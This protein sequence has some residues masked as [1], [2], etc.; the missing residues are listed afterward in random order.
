MKATRLDLRLDA[1]T[2]G[3]QVRAEAELAFRPQVTGRRFACLIGDVKI[4]GASWNGDPIEA[5]CNP[6]FLALRFPRKVDGFVETTIKLRYTYRPDA[7]GSIQQPTTKEACP[8]RVW[9]TVRRPLLGIL[10]GHL[11]E[12]TEKPPLRT[13][14]WEPPRSRKLALVVADVR[15]FRKTTPSGMNVWLHVHQDLAARAPRLLDLLVDLHEEVAESQRRKLPYADY[16]F[17]EADQRD[18]QPYN[19]LGI[20]VVPRGAFRVEDRPTLY[21]LLAPEVNKEWRRD[22]ATLVTNPNARNPRREGT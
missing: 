7:F 12:G 19:A 10:P 21:G 11:V 4:H 17:V 2:A 13:Y 9:V 8:E 15:S 3:A 22:P 20:V 14:Q 18:L 5:R 16:H 1:S 6:P